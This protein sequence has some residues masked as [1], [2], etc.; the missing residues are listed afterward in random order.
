MSAWSPTPIAG[1]LDLPDDLWRKGQERGL[2]FTHCDVVKYQNQ[3]LEGVDEGKRFLM[4][5]D[6]RYKFPLE[7]K[8]VR[9]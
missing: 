6:L 1:L 5:F 3:Q 7:T 8:V 2:G 9:R 4:S